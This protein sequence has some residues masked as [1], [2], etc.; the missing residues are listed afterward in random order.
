MKNSN[1]F[2]LMK[3]EFSCARVSGTRA[4]DEKF[5]VLIQSLWQKPNSGY[6]VSTALKGL[7]LLQ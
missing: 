7:S 1:V 3:L 5:Y 2:G 4:F 6:C